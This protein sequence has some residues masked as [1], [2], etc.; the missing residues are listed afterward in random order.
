MPCIST[1]I[2]SKN[3]CFISWVKPSL[4][5]HRRS[6]RKSSRTQTTTACNMFSQ[7]VDSSQVHAHIIHDKSALRIR[8]IARYKLCGSS[9]YRCRNR[10]LTACGRAAYR[11]LT[12]RSPDGYA[13]IEYLH[14]LLV[15]HRRKS[16][17]SMD[18]LSAISL[19][20]LSANISLNISSLP[21]KCL[22]IAP[23]VIPAAQQ[24]F[25]WSFL[26]ATF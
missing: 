20:P 5:H 10:S 17:S 7:I 15:G 9:G 18:S 8:C 19:F 2:A 4:Q 25:A 22:Y 11:P 14:Q 26:I 16:I 21:E 13:G 12:A 24:S 1:S 6:S 23:G 3:A